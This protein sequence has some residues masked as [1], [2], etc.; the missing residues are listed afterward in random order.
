M[1]LA[2]SIAICAAALALASSDVEALGTPAGTSI[3]NVAQV[4][5]TAGGSSLTATSNVSSITVAEILDAVV[6]TASP[7]VTTTPGAAQQ[8]LL[9]TLT[10]TGNGSEAFSLLGASAGI[11]GDDF[12]PD[13][14]APAIYFDTDN[15][16]D[17]SAADIA[18]VPGSNDPLLSADASVRVLVINSIPANVVNGNRGRSELSARAMTGTGLPGTPFNGQGDGGVDA[19]AG[20]TGADG[21][22]FGDYLIAGLQLAALKSQTILDASGSTRAQAGA[23]IEYRV[24]VTPSGSGTAAAATFT[25]LIPANTTYVAGSLQLNDTT[26]SDGADGDVGEFTAAPAPQVRVSLGD[27]TPASGPQTIEFAVTIN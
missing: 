14:A 5:Y 23:R 26:L 15:S 9:F 8:E 3:Q 12:D 11:G 2:R 18:Y 1:A 4:S 19:V 22:S 17:F 24:V 25:D 21:V 6:T 27:L 20:T 13:L 16:G 7:T 10:N